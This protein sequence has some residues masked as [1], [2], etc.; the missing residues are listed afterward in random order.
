MPAQAAIESVDVRAYEIPT[1]AA[2]TD[3]TLCWDATVLVLCSLRAAGRE[4]IGYSYANRATADVIHRDLRSRLLQSDALQPRA[5]WL[6][7]WQ[8]VRNLGRPGI[9]SMAIAAADMAAWDLFARLLDQPLFRV[10]GAYRDDVLAYGSG[11]F[12]SYSDDELAD[13]LDEWTAQGLAAA[14]IKIGRDESADRRRVERAREVLRADQALFVDG[15]G[16][17]EQRQALE[18]ARWLG[19]FGVSWFE[20]PVSSEDIAGMRW[21]RQR[22]PANVR[23]VTGEYGYSPA[24]FLRWLEAG[25]VDVLMADATRAGVSG[26]VDAAVLSATYHI[27][28]SSHCAPTIHAH[29][30]CAARNFLNAEYFIDHVRIE[31]RFFDGAIGVRGGRLAPDPSAPGIGVTPKLQDLDSHAI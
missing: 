18:T 9:A 14:K 4:G 22:G 19:D 6:R 15:N 30:G 8:Q 16:A 3:G 23:I 28:F 11:G 21:L 31:Q 5:T 25:A 10:L 2:E 12:T 24:D 17:Y 26:F 27:P 1:P 29:L 7:C 20:E 13:E